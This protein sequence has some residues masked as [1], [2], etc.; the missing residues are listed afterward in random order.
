MVYI[1]TSWKMGRPDGNGFLVFYYVKKV[2]VS[3][4]VYSGYSLQFD[5]K[6]F[7]Y[8]SGS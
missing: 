7:K 5:Q 3:R 8:F 2:I 4:T 6:S 1:T